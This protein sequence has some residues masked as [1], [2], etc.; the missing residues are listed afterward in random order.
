MR[1]GGNVCVCEKV[2]AWA[3]TSKQKISSLGNLQPLTGSSN[4]LLCWEWLLIL[5]ILQWHH[6]I[7]SCA[8]FRFLRNL[9]LKGMRSCL[10]FFF[11]LIVATLFSKCLAR[12][13]TSW[14]QDCQEKY[15]QPQICRWYQFSSRKWR[16]T[17]EPLD[18]DKRGRVNWLKTQHSE[19]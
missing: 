9:V 11:F 3:W 6:N 5:E 14:N 16:G 1:V 8:I 4:A 7:G 17:E 15:Q 10:C 19:N 2:K 12:R 18:K 13:S